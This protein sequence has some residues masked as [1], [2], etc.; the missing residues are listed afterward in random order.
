MGNVSAM[1]NLI[2]TNTV[3][4]S[5]QLASKISGS[6]NKGF[7]Y[8]GTISGSATST[9][10]FSNIQATTVVGDVSGLTGLI[11]SG[12]VSVVLLKLLLP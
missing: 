4:G 10:S 9:G 6:F 8:E 11:P 12:I 5:S 1:T 2:P 7:E 3:S